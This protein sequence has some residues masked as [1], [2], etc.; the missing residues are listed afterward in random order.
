LLFHLT[1]PDLLDFVHDYIAV[2]YNCLN[3][4]IVVKDY[5]VGSELKADMFAAGDKIDVSGTSK[6]KGF[7][8]TIKR[9][10]QHR[11]PMSHGSRYH[12]RPGS[13]GPSA[14]PGRVL[15]TKKLPGR[16]GFERVTV[17]NLEVVKVDAERNLLL[18]KGAIPGSKGTLLTIKETV[19]N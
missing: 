5:K 8:G 19:K 17:A 12:R 13:L 7:A 16:M 9:W 1:I 15:R 11:G 10:N 3:V 18:I 4:Y 2:C 14:T 6:G